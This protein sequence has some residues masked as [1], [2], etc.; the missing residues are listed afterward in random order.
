MSDSNT[1][2][3]AIEAINDQLAQLDADIQASTRRLEVDT[4]VRDRLLDLRGTLSRKP[5]GR[6]PRVVEAMDPGVKA[7]NDIDLDKRSSDPAA[8][9]W[10]GFS[11][12]ES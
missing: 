3:T 8:S 9:A 10:N 1:H 2:D 4:A 12:V 11:V 5:R 6:R 7:Q